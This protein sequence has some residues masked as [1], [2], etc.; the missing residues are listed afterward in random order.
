MRWLPA[1]KPPRG[2]SGPADTKA[3]KTHDSLPTLTTATATAPTTAIIVRATTTIESRTDGTVQNTASM[4]TG[5]T[6]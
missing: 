2:R 1:R 6:E 4:T 5:I 3:T